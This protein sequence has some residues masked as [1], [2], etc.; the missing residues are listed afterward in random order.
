M[1]D[2]PKKID[3][4]GIAVRSIEERL[5]YYEQVLGLP[6]L[7]IESIP[8]QRIKVAFLSAG[9]VNLELLEATDHH[10]TVARFIAKKGEG[11]HHIAFQVNHIQAR[12]RELKK[13]SVHP[14]SLINGAHGQTVTFLNPKVSGGVLIE[15]CEQTTLPNEN[16]R[17]R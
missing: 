16:G 10:S 2:P 17:N 9:N 14:G 4:I 12:I 1:N 3:H 13:Q 15:L 5:P 11:I 8:S 7:G 6:F